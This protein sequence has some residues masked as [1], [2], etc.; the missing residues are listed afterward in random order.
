MTNPPV[1]GMPDFSVPFILE[2]DASGTGIGA[3]LMQHNR[4]LAF[5]SQHLGPR[6]CAASIY[7]K[8]AMAIF[9]ALKKWR[10]YLL[11]NQVIIRTDQQSLKYLT[12]Q[13]LLEGMQHKL[14][15]KLLEFNYII[16]YKKGA[17]NSVAD[18]LSRRFQ[19]TEP[20]SCHA[21]SHAIPVWMTDVAATYDDDQACLKLLQELAVNATSNNTFSLH[22]G[23][24]RYK[25]RIYVG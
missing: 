22:D 1:L 19:D 11:G 15:L 18:A 8:E 13:R 5:F 14:M 24:I 20:D 2:T 7:E 10:H 25:G 12:S 3:L 16:E 4:L 21:T 9:H 17:E 6:N 23:I